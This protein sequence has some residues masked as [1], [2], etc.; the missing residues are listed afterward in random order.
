MR[1]A[2]KTDVGRKRTHNED[3]IL[4][5]GSMNI[6][7]LADGM[8]GRQAGEVASD[9]AVKECYA[10]LKE[11]FKRAKREEDVS[12]LLIESLLKAHDAVKAKSMTDVNLMG[13]GTTLTEMVIK[14]DEAH[15][16]HIGD[17][18]VYLLRK[19]IKQITKD[20]TTEMYFIKDRIVVE[21]FLPLQKMRVLTQAVGAQETL[22]PEVKQVKLKPADIL[23]LCSDGLTDM[24][25]DKEIESII[26]RGRDNLTT[27][28]DSLI[29]EANNE[30]GIDNISVIL[31]GYE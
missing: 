15:I 30:G 17:C 14:K 19:E 6:F 5:D 20:H 12:K 7:L 13:M 25:S 31:I 1:L 4:A 24:L 3:S 26:Q 2:Y 9:L 11:N 23:L 21:G 29:Q 16:C 27:V 8:G 18:R 22:E 10:W 28:A